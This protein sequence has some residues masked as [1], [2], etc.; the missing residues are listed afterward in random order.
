[1][2]TVVR[3]DDLTGVTLQSGTLPANNVLPFVVF[4]EDGLTLNGVRSGQTLILEDGGEL[5]GEFSAVNANLN[6]RG[7]TVGANLHLSDTVADISGGTLGFRRSFF[8]GFFAYSGSTVNI[9][10][11]ALID[12]LSLALSGSEVNIS[13]GTTDTVR[14]NAGSVV[15][16]SNGSAGSVVTI[17]GGTFTDFD[18]FLDSDVTIRGGEFLLNGIALANPATVTLNES[19]VL[20]GTLQDGSVFVFS[21]LPSNITSSHELQGV[22]FET[23]ALTA[24][25]LTPIVVD[26]A[27]DVAPTGLRAGQSLTLRGDGALGS[28]FVSVGAALNIEGGSVDDSEVVSSTVTISEGEVARLAALL[29]SAISLSGGQVDFLSLSQSSAEISGGSLGGLIVGSG[30]EVELTGGTLGEFT[31]SDGGTLNVRGGTITGNVGVRS[32]GELNLFVTE[33]FIDDVPVSDLVP[34]EPRTILERDVTLSG[35]LADGSE[36]SFSP[37]FSISVRLL[38]SCQMAFFKLKRIVTKT[39]K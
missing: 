25:D 36:F 29:G 23:V 35:L 6:I 9:S 16:V 3:G 22:A 10:G 11:D 30:S 4:T 37:T 31:V 26:D 17:S 28:D 7:G 39:V 34:G 1:L 5:R 12:G 2:S 13:G 18:A 19:D 27:L 33:A 32:G 24:A 8:G 20:T 14:A 21:R 15:N 38:K